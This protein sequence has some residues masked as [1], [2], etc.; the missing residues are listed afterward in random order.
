MR[1]PKWVPGWPE[2]ERGED[3]RLMVIPCHYCYCYF[4]VRVCIMTRIARIHCEKKFH[5][6][7]Q[8]PLFYYSAHCD[9]IP[10]KSLSFAVGKGYMPACLEHENSLSF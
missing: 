8:E 2:E 7:N 5:F 1:E 3:P 9:E 6:M 4:S 10:V